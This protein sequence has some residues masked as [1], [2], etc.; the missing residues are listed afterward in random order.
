M[1]VTSASPRHVKHQMTFSDELYDN[2]G[3]RDKLTRYRRDIQDNLQWT[4]TGNHLGILGQ[5]QV[6]VLVSVSVEFPIEWVC[7]INT[8]QTGNK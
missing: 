8:S 6:S 5:N 2:T 3:L 1:H 7:P 4:L